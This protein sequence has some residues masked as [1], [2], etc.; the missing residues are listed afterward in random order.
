MK[1]SAAAKSASA[2]PAPIVAEAETW[3]ALGELTADIVGD[4]D[5]RRPGAA[6]FPGRRKL[7]A[8]R[9]PINV[10]EPVYHN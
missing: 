8:N 6:R 9:L 10:C 4:L 1:L 5:Q 7:V 2:A 3:L